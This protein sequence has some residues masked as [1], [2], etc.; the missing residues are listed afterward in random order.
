MKNL[1]LY[2]FIRN[3]IRYSYPIRKSKDNIFLFH[4]IFFAA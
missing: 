3:K 1:F 2:L 4:L